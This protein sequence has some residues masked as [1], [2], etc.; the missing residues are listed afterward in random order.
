MTVGRAARLCVRLTSRYPPQASNSESET[1]GG[2]KEVDLSRLRNLLLRTTEGGQ[3]QEKPNN[4][5]VG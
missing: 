4:K 5:N 3:L 1:D 2:D